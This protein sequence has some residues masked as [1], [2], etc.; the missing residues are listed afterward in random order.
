MPMAN[1][2]KA[3]KARFKKSKYRQMHESSKSSDLFY[4]RSGARLCIKFRF[5]PVEMPESVRLE[6]VLVFEIWIEWDPNF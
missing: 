1:K 3:M 6:L 4:F 5:G 2:F